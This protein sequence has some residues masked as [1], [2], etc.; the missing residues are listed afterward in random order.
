MDTGMSILH[1]MKNRP[2]SKT[3]GASLTRGETAETTRRGHSD[4]PAPGEG[5]WSSSTM[6][7]PNLGREGR[8]IFNI[9]YWTLRWDSRILRTDV[10]SSDY[11]K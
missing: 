7:S 1:E 2:T 3:S 4:T 8:D 9:D 6:Y 5:W 10:V 11:K